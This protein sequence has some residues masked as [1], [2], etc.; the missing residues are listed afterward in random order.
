MEFMKKNLKRGFTIVEL[1]IAIAVIAILAALLIPTFVNVSKK[2]K[3]ASDT[4]L[5]KNINTALAIAEAEGYVPETMEEVTY[6]LSRNGYKLENLN[7]TASG[8][9][10]VWNQTTN[11]VTYLA[12]DKSVIY[13]GDSTSTSDLD[14]DYWLTVKSKSDMDNFA[15][16]SYYLACDMTDAL[17]F[18]EASCLDT[19]IYT[20]S[21]VT[22]THSGSVSVSGYVGT[23]TVNSVNAE[24]NNYSIV[25]EV[26]IK[27]ASGNSYHEYG[28]AEKITVDASATTAN[29]VIENEGIVGQLTVNAS[30]TVTV[31]GYVKQADSEKYTTDGGAVGE[32]TQG[33][34]YL[35]SGYQSL[36]RF[37]NKVNS[38]MNFE[39]LTVELTADIDISGYCWVPIGYD[40]RDNYKNPKYFYF[41]GVFDGNG[42]TVSGLSNVGFTPTTT[43]VDTYGTGSEIA[44]ENNYLYGFFG[45]VHG[46]KILNLNLTDVDIVEDS[47]LVLDSI[48]A[49]IGYVDGCV[50]VENCNASGSIAA[51]DAVGGLIGRAYDNE[52][53][54]SKAFTADGT[55][56]S[57]S[58]TSADK[59]NFVI[60]NCTANVE[61]YCTGAKAAGILGYTGTAVGYYL[62]DCTAS[63][64]VTMTKTTTNLYYAG[65]LIS[66]NRG[67]HS[68]WKRV[69]DNCNAD[70]MTLIGSPA[71]KAKIVYGNKSDC[72]ITYDEQTNVDLTQSYEWNTL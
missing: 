41:A 24:V 36:K 48:G 26:E 50:Y 40:S 45:I 30:K 4:T 68:G 23:L 33:Y 11:R 17:E 38:G 72:K 64:S 47:E 42:H 39:N 69:I 51:N 2:A 61:I 25:D 52:L 66:T 59:Y 43:R 70:D 60:K 65:I 5:A 8:N 63:G 10:F 15:G 57:T 21:S 12:S 28:Y 71:N 56:I 54:Y 14:S 7:P 62:K 49:L 32:S 37:R 3:E 31:K 58:D 6:T 44:Q 27:A 53:S 34:V 22:Y 16:L 18:S 1:V 55:E 13:T 19:G 67:S 35:I 20:A 46:A 29:V 9:V